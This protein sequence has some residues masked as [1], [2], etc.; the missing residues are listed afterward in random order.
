MVNNNF[1]VRFTTYKERA[2]LDMIKKEKYIST[3]EMIYQMISK[4]IKA[5]RDFFHLQNKDICPSADANLI[6]A[7]INNRRDIKKNK[8]LIPDGVK[9]TYISENTIPFIDTIA[10]NL[11][12]EST[13]ELLIGTYDEL[14]AYSEELFQ[15]LIKDALVDEDEKISKEINNLLCDYIPYAKASTYFDLQEQHGDITSFVIDKQFQ[16]DIEEYSKLQMY[17]IARIYEY[18]KIEFKEYFSEFFKIQPNT[19]KLNN[20]LSKFVITKLLPLIKSYRRNIDLIESAK[21]MLSKSYDK[22]VY[23]AN[24]ELKLSPETIDYHEN[25]IS[26]YERNTIYEWILAEYDFITKLEEIQKNTEGEPNITLLDNT[27][28]CKMCLNP[29]LNNE[30]NI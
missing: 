7:I 27:W 22:L 11:S 4:R 12:Y 16:Y 14:E 2:I 6:S 9:G 21:Q 13:A 26:Y 23:Y 28:N 10:S 30:Q 5:R 25:D 15:R 20:R 29:I 18:V 1:V 17:A 8:Y 24:Y 19:L 3:C